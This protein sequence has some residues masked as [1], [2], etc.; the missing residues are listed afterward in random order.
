[1][2]QIYDFGGLQAVRDHVDQN[3][4]QA[5]QQAAFTEMFSQMFGSAMPGSGPSMF[6]RFESGGPGGASRSSKPAPIVHQCSITLEHVYQQRP[7]HFDISVRKRAPV[8]GGFVQEVR[9]FKLQFKSWNELQ[10]QMTF[11]GKGHDS[12]DGNLETG[13]IVVHLAV[14]PHPHFTP[15][16]T[17]DLILKRTLTLTES[18]CGFDFTVPF[19][20]SAQTSLRLRSELNE[21]VGPG[22]TYKAPFG[23]SKNNAGAAAAI[24]VKEA[25]YNNSGTLFVIC[26]VET[27]T[28]MNAAERAN[29]ASKLTKATEHQSAPNLIP[30]ERTSPLRAFG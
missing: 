3:A 16:N 24:A 17:H 27:P 9:Q 2:R 30:L 10:R 22:A 26:D 23:L 7:I 29:L 15:C 13:D 12:A 5:T 20:D 19:L 25:N 6:F 21:V 8:N 14:Q 28:T 11:N 4:S 18:L 1:M